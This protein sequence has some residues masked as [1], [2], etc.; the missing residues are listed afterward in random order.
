[1]RPEDA[2]RDLGLTHD[3]L[4]RRWH[5]SDAA[6]ARAVEIALACM[7]IDAAGSPR[8][9]SLQLLAVRTLGLLDS[10]NV[11]R[12]RNVIARQGI[13]SDARTAD[14]RAVL[15]TPEG[16]AALAQLSAQMAAP[17]LPHPSATAEAESM[18]DIAG[19]VPPAPGVRD[20]TG[21]KSTATDE[22]EQP[23]A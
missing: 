11:R 14:L 3:A 7:E 2:R 21:S 17:A 18:T 13:Q 10:L 15:A 4:A 5:I 9:L 20:E 23:H 1:M 16:R 6:R 12:E 8:L 22:P 19:S